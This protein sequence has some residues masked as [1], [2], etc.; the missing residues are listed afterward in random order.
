MNE[1]ERRLVI[2][3][4]KRESLLCELLS[5]LENDEEKGLTTERPHL[6]NKIRT[7]LNLLH[8]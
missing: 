5:I 7:E 3:C 2:D 4:G 8:G 1:L 6:I